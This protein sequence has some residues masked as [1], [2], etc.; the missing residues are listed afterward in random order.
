MNLG[1]GWWKRGILSSAQA[2][3]RAKARTQ[4]HMTHGTP[5]FLF[6]SCKLNIEASIS[7]HEMSSDAYNQPKT[8]KT[9]LVR[10]QA[11]HRNHVISTA[12][13]ARYNCF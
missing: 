11:R 8:A 9:V 3:F 7:K 4:Y 2:T 10:R 6:F 13:K 1:D 12:T 5:Q